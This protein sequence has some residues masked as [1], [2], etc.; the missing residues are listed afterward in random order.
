MSRKL[1]S[2]VKISKV[3]NIENSDRLAVAN[4]EGKSWDVVVGKTE[5]NVGDIAVYYEIDSALPADDKRYEF[6]HERCLKQ[7]MEGNVVVA[8]FVRIKTI[9]LRGVLSQGLLMPISLFPELTGCNVGDDVTDILSVKHIDNVYVPVFAKKCCA[10]ETIKGPFPYDIIPKTDEERIQNLE[11]YFSDDT[12]KDKTFEVTCKDDGSSMT[13]F[14]TKTY[15]PDNPFGFCSRNYEKKPDVKGDAFACY[16]EKHSLKEL[17]SKYCEDNDVE[18]A[19]Q[20][21][22]LGPRMNG[23]RD[24]YTDHEWHVF[25]IWDIK[26]Q[27]FLIPT[28]RREVC[29]E[30]NLKHVS[31]ISENMEVFKIFKSGKEI[32]KY[33]EGKT[34]RGNEREGLVFKENTENPITFKAVSNK[35]LLKNKG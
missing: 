19:I 26:R 21:E 24:L 33:A 34:S 25:R 6:L 1:A 20:G 23:N 15:R 16:V 28:K 4:M 7:Y 29:K 31:V 27:C 14:Y 9:K 18:L 17:L 3:E 10:D 11:K 8:S 22:L 35:Y 2:I 5:Y 13:I 12:L 32:L 30:L